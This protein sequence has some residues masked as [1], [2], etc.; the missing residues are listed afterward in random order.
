MYGHNS[1]CADRM[2]NYFMYEN[3]RRNKFV[4]EYPKLSATDRHWNVA[5][6]QCECNLF[7]G[8]QVNAKR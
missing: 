5:I 7:I 2:R 8:G 6:V 1:I 3:K 4:I